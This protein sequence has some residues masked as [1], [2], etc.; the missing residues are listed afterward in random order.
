MSA[1][2]DG[3]R[4]IV[5]RLYSSDE[6]DDLMFKMMQT[7]E[8]TKLEF[9]RL[10]SE[11]EEVRDL[12]RSFQSGHGQTGQT[13]RVHEPQELRT[14]LFTDISMLLESIHRTNEILHQLKRLMPHEP[15][16]ASLR[17]RHRRWLKACEGF[18]EL[19]NRFD[20]TDY[21]EVQGSVF[22]LNGKTLDFGAE[23]ESKT[24]ALFQDFISV[25]E[26]AAEK[27]RKI[28][29]LISRRESCS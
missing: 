13:S 7:M 25:W 11:L 24:E 21:G 6:L 5:Q 27:K 17:N 4:T 10:R 23:L 19:L 15:E 16:I 2:A 26:R 8:V 14:A 28:R 22:C 1:Q 12:E 29:D 9:K 20:M 18:R 3:K